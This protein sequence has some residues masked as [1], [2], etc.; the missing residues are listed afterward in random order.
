MKQLLFS[1]IIISAA[2]KYGPSGSS[3]ST[4]TSSSNCGKKCSQA[5]SV[6]STSEQLKSVGGI[7]LQSVPEPGGISFGAGYYIDNTVEVNLGIRL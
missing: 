5:S 4:V 6:T 3:S 7:K 1:A 2:M